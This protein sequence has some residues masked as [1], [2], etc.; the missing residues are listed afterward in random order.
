V[1]LLHPFDD[2]LLSVLELQFLVFWEIKALLTFVDVL[3]RLGL[4]S[5]FPLSVPEV[6]VR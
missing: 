1:V 2:P 3:L 6:F 5:G 4:T